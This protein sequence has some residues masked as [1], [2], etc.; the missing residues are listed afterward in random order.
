MSVLFDAADKHANKRK[1]KLLDDGSAS[2]GLFPT[3][4]R[5]P[6]IPLVSNVDVAQQSTFADNYAH[7]DLSGR[8]VDF[9]WAISCITLIFP[10]AFDAFSP[11]FAS[12]PAHTLDM[13]YRC[14]FLYASLFLSLPGLSVHLFCLFLLLSNRCRAGFWCY[15]TSAASFVLSVELHCFY[16]VQGWCALIF[17]VSVVVGITGQALLVRA[18]QGK[19]GT[20]ICAWYGTALVLAVVG[21]LGQIWPADSS[22]GSIM[23]TG[24]LVGAASIMWIASTW[25]TL[26]PVRVAY[27]QLYKT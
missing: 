23:F 5:S 22:D 18:I 9:V 13:P 1:N 3:H 20:I 26:L 10:I 16:R 8:H 14:D 4:A 27:V 6:L 12:Q 11:R 19:Q 15:L 17:F 24:G 2:R 25:L 21:L 7:L